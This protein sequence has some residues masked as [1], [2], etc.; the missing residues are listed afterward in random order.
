NIIGIIS[1]GNDITQEES[2][3]QQLMLSS[4]QYETTFKA[5]QIGIAHVALDGSWI[6]VNDYL[7]HLIGYTKEE[8]L[9]LTFQDITHPDDLQKDMAY[10]KQLID[11]KR[12]TYG[13]EK[14]Y[15]HKNGNIIWIYLSVYL[16]RKSNEEPLYFISTI[17]D[18]SQIKM[19][20]FEL[21]ERKTEL[22]NII[23]FAP[24][25]IILHDEDGLILMLNEVWSEIT[26]YSLKETPTL[27]IWAEKIVGASQ[28]SLLKSINNLHTPEAQIQEGEYTMHTKEGKMVTWII[29][30]APLGKLH[31][32]KHLM[33]VS[34]MDVTELQSHEKLM[35][36]QSRQAAMGDMIG[37]I[38]HQWRQPLTV[39]SMVANNLKAH[40]EL[41]ELIPT[42]ELEKLTTVLSE[43]TQY[44][45]HTI[46]DFR[47][48]FR[49]DKRKENVSL[50]EIYDKLKTIVD[51][52][53]ENNQI[54]LSFSKDCTMKILT[55]PNELVQVLINLINNSKDAIKEQN[56]QNG[57]INIQTAHEG[58]SLTITVQDNGGGIEA[59]VIE[60]LGE[61]YIT[62]KKTNGTGLGLYMSKIIIEKHLDGRL[63]WKNCDEGSCF[64][65]IL[66]YEI[67]TK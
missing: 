5:A 36:S 21:D 34:A 17:Q 47:N 24:N 38:A 59:S 56:I 42:P 7:S 67:D 23:K 28:K 35:L 3:T 43:Q 20:M 4:L 39:I 62:T 45:S 58:T 65:I 29:S 50:C 60:Q 48:F 31:N 61:P 9:S 33:I 8:L 16:L 44:L 64:S 12:E 19:L 27:Q 14:R 54:T 13:M 52:T 63:Q 26:G 55:F 51:K 40:L 53:L 66:P 30:S 41:E 15:I 2:L 1:T 57:K 32:N 22:E 49:P 46:D 11:G 10:V 37:M 18:I 25:P 6:D